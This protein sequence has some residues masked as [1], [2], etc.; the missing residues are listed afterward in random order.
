MN[1]V[2]L[3]IRDSRFEMVKEANSL[4]AVENFLSGAANDAKKKRE[5]TSKPVETIL[6]TVG[7]YLFSRSII[8]WGLLELAK[9]LG[10]DLFGMIG[11]IVDDALG[12]GGSEVTEVSD[13]GILAAAKKAAGR[14]WN[15]IKDYLS[16]LWDNILGGGISLLS[17]REMDIVKEARNPT[18]F[19][20]FLKD[21]RKGGRLSVASLLYG[22][23]KVVFLGIAGSAVMAG[24]VK[25]MG[26]T[27][28]AEKEE[29][30]RQYQERVAPKTN[31]QHYKNIRYNVEDSL[32][33]YMNAA[34]GANKGHKS[35]ESIFETVKGRPLRGSDEMR[36]VLSEVSRLY[37]HAPIERISTYETFYGPRIVSVIQNMVPEMRKP[38]S[39][40]IVPA[41]SK[42][43]A[44][45]KKPKKDPKKE[46]K[47]LLKGVFND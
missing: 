34:V 3:S 23:L 31:L 47:Q 7:P 17:S 21:I 1:I 2:A 39:E 45:P 28:I 11:G 13:S 25:V 30:G 14:L 36:K 41:V 12:L 38:S 22:I 46:L 9:Q 32:I 27:P 4:G 33:A 29:R 19:M 18:K 44:A 24:T 8:G 16:G 42:P 26:V 10:F 37:D 35:F 6:S 5:V 40:P 15:K 20:R 43:R